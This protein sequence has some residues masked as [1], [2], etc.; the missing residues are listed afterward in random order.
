M[1]VKT[2]EIMASTP[3]WM[4]DRIPAYKEWRYHTTPFPA[5]AEMGTDMMNK[6]AIN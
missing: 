4:A 5:A 6:V 3:A 2:A 1:G